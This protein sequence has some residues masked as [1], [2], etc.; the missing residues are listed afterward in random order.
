MPLFDLLIHIQSKD[1][2]T[3]HKALTTYLK[4]PG[5]NLNQ[6]QN[7]R[8]KD[9][10]YIVS[11]SPLMMAASM[12]QIKTAELLLENGADI[13]YQVSCEQRKYHTAL[14]AA[15]QSGRLRMVSFLLAQGAKN[16]PDP[17]D[18]RHCYYIPLI[19]AV[20]LSRI[21][22]IG[23]LLK[24]G[25][26]INGNYYRTPPLAQ[27]IIL[28]SHPPTEHELSLTHFLIEQGA[29]C[30]RRNFIEVFYKPGYEGHLL[31][32]DSVTYA[33]KRAVIYT[34]C[35]QHELPLPLFNRNDEK[36]ILIEIII[37][38]NQ[39]KKLA[40][41]KGFWLAKTLLPASVIGIIGEYSFENENYQKALTFEF[42]RATNNPELPTYSG[43]YEDPVPNKCA[44]L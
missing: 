30:T 43:N 29:H 14:I 31:K 21:D 15:I 27:S 4:I 20:K 12:G 23:L 5:A 42:N 18:Y 37:H 35:E 3:F 25:A 16:D 6:S 32:Y 8:L 17:A 2:L 44:I 9:T 22:I 11:F 36:N 7:I 28:W 26:N 33:E 41:A 13:D 24:N 34:L 40:K 1:P 10:G 39:I 19:E 38:N